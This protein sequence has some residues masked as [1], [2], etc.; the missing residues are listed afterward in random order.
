[1]ASSW[2]DSPSAFGM[3]AGGESRPAHV[4]WGM[5]MACDA[6]T[7]NKNPQ[8]D[9]LLMRAYEVYRQQQLDL[10]RPA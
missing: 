10:N 8:D 2:L 1:M 6:A 3:A 9:L 5:G 4:P 7:G